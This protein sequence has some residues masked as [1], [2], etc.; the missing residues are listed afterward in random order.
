VPVFD[1]DGVSLEVPDA[2][3]GP[4]LRHALGTGLYEHREAHAL[5]THLK[6]SDRVLD[7]GAGCGYLSILAAGFVG[8]GR[9]AAVEP[10]PALLP[11]I[12][13][14]VA[15]NDLAPITV[16][17]GAAVPGEGGGEVPLFRREGFWSGSTARGKGGLRDS[18]E[19]PA[20]GIGALFTDLRPTVLVADIEGAEEGLFDAGLPDPV[21][22]AVIELHPA[23]YGARGIAAI[24]D[25]FSRS[26]FA[27]S[28]A[29]SRGRV[30][31]FSRLPPGQCGRARSQA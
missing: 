19:V 3:L 22:L 24:F 1:V 12:A 20:L 9:V 8:P 17:H 26:G 10:N 15:R 13:G 16:L 28:P 27:Y 29:G 4:G 7:L 18:I 30:V 23:Q 2:E 11:V 21:R 14:N 25:A 6:S 5:S 31:V